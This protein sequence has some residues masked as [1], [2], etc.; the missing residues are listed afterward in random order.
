MNEDR[1]V[2]GGGGGRVG[3]GGGHTDGDQIAECAGSDLEKM[4]RKIGLSGNDMR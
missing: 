4:G 3:W 1:G 2:E